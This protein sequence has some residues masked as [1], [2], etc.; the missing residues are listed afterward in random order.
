MVVHKYDVARIAEK[1]GRSIKY[2][3]DRVKLLQLTKE[4]QQLFLE[5]RIT[6]GHAILLARLKPAD[7]KRAID[8]DTNEHR[9]ALFQKEH[10]LFDPGEQAEEPFKL[11]GKDPWKGLKARSVRE[12][13][14]WIDEHV[15][16]DAK[17]PDPI[18]FP[19]TKAEL[20]G[21]KKI[22]PITLA[23]YIPEEAREGRTWGPRSW[24]RADGQPYSDSWGRKQK[25]KTC[26]YSVTGFVA[27]GPGRGDAFPVCVNKDKCAIHWPDQVR[28]KKRRSA[29]VAGKPTKTAPSKPAK[30]KP[31]KRVIQPYEIEREAA[32]AISEAVVS[33]AEG[34]SPDKFLR[35]FALAYVCNTGM[36]S[37]LKGMPLAKLQ[38]RLALEL[39]DQI[40]EACEL[41]E[42]FGIDPKP[43]L[44]AAKERLTKPKAG[45]CSECGCTEN[46][47]CEDGCSWA[48]QEKTLCTSCAPSTGS[49]EKGRNVRKARKSGSGKPR[50][51]AR[52]KK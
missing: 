30:A 14:G 7:Q 31:E 43:F 50:A 9:P 24:K 6:A 49:T 42:A 16:F 12:L 36:A 23:N 38:A 5:D 11:K 13:Q 26:E 10:T 2:V 46:D 8:P 15:R 44:A 35:I 19:E 1:I 25:S 28:A 17:E 37:E 34:L 27:V 18:L 3:Y 41:A 20:E 45:T 32:D 39:M 21:A 48:N 47:A 33:K 29:A 22:V 51:K 4:A 40:G 52:K